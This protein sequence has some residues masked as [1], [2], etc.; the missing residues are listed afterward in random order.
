MYPTTAGVVLADK[1]L[2]QVVQNCLRQTRTRLVL[3]HGDITRWSEFLLQL[4]RAQPDVLVLNLASA[5]LEEMIRR[6]Q[7]VSQAPLIVIHESLDPQ[8]IL[9]VIRAGAKE[10]VYPPYEQHLLEALGR[11]AEQRAERA[12]PREASGSVVGLL[13]V[14]GGC[15]ATTVACHLAAELQRLTQKEILLAD[16]AITA[17]TVGLLMGAK[18]PYS[19]LDAAENIDR[20]DLS[21]WKTLVSNGLPRLEVITSPAAPVLNGP[22][23]PEPF[24]EVLRF[25]RSIYDWTVADLGRGLNHFS[26][27]LMEDMDQILLVTHAEVPAFYQTKN[28]VQALR[29]LGYREDRLHLVVNRAPKD[30]DFT[31]QEVERLIGL[32]VRAKL[33]NSYPE[34]TRAH[35]QARLLSPDTPLGKQLTRVAMALA[36]I[37]NGG[38]GPAMP[39]FEVKQVAAGWGRV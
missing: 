37:E 2:V 24:R 8:I 39:L 16:L 21:Y 36:G 25:A 5:R 31:M 38:G 23:A 10:Y 33:P 35:A 19:I 18:T 30:S 9:G 14:K 34:L 1:G 7:T 3:Q 6:I 28:I 4:E 22:L 32:P 27:S 20:L 26:L 17:G 12:P 15:G 29:S 13:S 11:I